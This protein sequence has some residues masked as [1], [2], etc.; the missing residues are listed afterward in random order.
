MHKVRYSA[1]DDHEKVD[2]SLEQV[3]DVIEFQCSHF[4]EPL[5]QL[6]CT[7]QCFSIETVYYRKV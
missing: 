3:S 6:M 2:I 5:K 1:D 4:R 7:Y